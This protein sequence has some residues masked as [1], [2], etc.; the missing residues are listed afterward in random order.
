MD[1]NTS[2]QHDCTVYPNG[3]FMSFDLS[4]SG[5]DKTVYSCACGE[6]LIEP[7]D[8]GTGA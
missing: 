1:G 7:E 2:K 3:H 6:I 5:P 8:S 4:M